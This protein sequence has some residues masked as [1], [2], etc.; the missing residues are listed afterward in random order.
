M[1]KKHVLN[2]YAKIFSNTN[3][4]PDEQNEEAT[5]KFMNEESGFSRAQLLD[6]LRELE[7]LANRK[8]PEIE[9]WIEI[10]SL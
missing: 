6:L 4:T 2:E 1:S 5:N 7:K 10:N 9:L 8:L 3:L